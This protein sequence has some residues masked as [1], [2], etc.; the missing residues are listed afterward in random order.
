VALGFTVFSWRL[1]YLQVSQ[2]DYYSALAMEI[3]ST[4][5][6]IYARRGSIVDRSGVPLAANE[7]VKTVVIDATLLRNPELGA[8][9][10]S[11]HLEMP[12]SAVLER[13]GKQVWSATDQKMHPSPYIVIKHE[14]AEHVAEA[15][16]KEFAEKSQRG[17]VLEQE[18]IRVYPNG[19]MLCHVVG[20]LNHEGVGQEG[21]ERSMNDW[22]KGHDGFRYTE[23]DRRGKELVAFRRLERPP[24]DGDTVRL[25]VDMALQDIVESELDVAVKQYRPKMATCIVMR[26]ATGEILALAN[27]PHYDLN[28]RDGVK[29]EVR[30]NRA[31]MDQVEPGSTFKIVTTAAALDQKL[32]R[33]DTV[34]NC[35]S[36]KFTYGGST[37]HDHGHGYGELSVNDVLVKSSN[38]GVAK[39][40]LMLKDQLLYEYARRFGFGERTGVQLPGEIPGIVHPPHRWS[41][42][43][44]THIP[45]GHE[46]GATPM[47][48]ISAM[49][50]IANRGRLMIPQIVSSI[51]DSTNERTTEFP[52]VEVRQVIPSEVAE[53][54]V[55]ALTEVVSKKGT[56]EKAHV[57]GFLVAGKT[58]TAQKF[59]PSGGYEHNKYV[60]SFAGFFPADKPEL[61]AL[62]LIDDAVAPS[63]LNY[64]GLIA[65]P[66]F[67]R[68]GQRA[69]RHL[70]MTPSPEL[71]KLPAPLAQTESKGRR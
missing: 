17:L 28:Q 7:P 47:Q 4:R 38:I 45:M 32:V 59:S 14:V 60:V 12:K 49:C 48:V 8:E 29:D 22:L 39:M 53:K 31:I 54:L 46:V 10:L 2:H 27:R 33:A 30:K 24:R 66:V 16:Q 44:I 19:G 41:K 57:P 67:S 65:A 13:L 50:T 34:I 6:T 5:Q 61:C 69:A 56:A 36:G 26:P 63:N 23:R 11:R 55:A 42:I 35:E 15:L 43:S 1:V 58:G 70:N 52:P 51:T 18:S 71:M 25:T 9:I 37:L 3:H 68:I 20:F 40:G 64:G 21:V 62:V